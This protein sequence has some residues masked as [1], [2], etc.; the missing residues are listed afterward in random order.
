MDVYTLH[1]LQL[2]QLFT[3]KK[4]M[5]LKNARKSFQKTQS[6]MCFTTKTETRHGTGRID[7][8]FPFFS[9]LSRGPELNR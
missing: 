4:N 5:D 9:L 1:K 7:H 8:C 2:Q 6:R 3:S